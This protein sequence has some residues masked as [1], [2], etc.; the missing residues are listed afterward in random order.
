MRMTTKNIL[1]ISDE[2][3]KIKSQVKQQH[4]NELFSPKGGEHYVSLVETMGTDKRVVGFVIAEHRVGRGL[5]YNGYSL[6][7]HN[8]CFRKSI[9]VALKFVK[10]EFKNNQ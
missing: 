2:F 1:C 7:T 9:D 3:Q 6:L 5:R 4:I 10:A 8:V